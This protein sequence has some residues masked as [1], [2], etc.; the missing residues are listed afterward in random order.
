MKPAGRSIAFLFVAGSLLTALSFATLSYAVG[1]ERGAKVGAF[2]FARRPAVY[3]QAGPRFIWSCL[4]K[5]VTEDGAVDQCYPPSVSPD[6]RYVIC[7]AVASGLVPPHDD[8]ETLHFYLFDRRTGGL[9]VIQPPGNAIPAQESPRA[10]FGPDGVWVTM[11]FW[12]RRATS[13]ARDVF[14]YNMVTHTFRPVATT[15]DDE[16]DG[17]VS[18]GGQAVAYTR[19]HREEEPSQV[20]VTDTS[21]QWISGVISKNANGELGNDDSW[22]AKI[23]ADG[24]YV[25]FVSKATYRPSALMDG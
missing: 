4:R 15:D 22:G 11:T 14:L 10:W 19:R 13:F 5:P 1:W 21:G 3:P 17:T 12:V 18:R 20:V 25:A 23:S 16:W 7:L 6:G 2:P 9:A 8:D 24:R